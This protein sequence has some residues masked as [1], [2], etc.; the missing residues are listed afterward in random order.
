MFDAQY[1]HM[2]MQQ[3]QHNGFNKGQIQHQQQPEHQSRYPPLSEKSATEIMFDVMLSG[4]Q[5]TATS[6]AAFGQPGPTG[7]VALNN[8]TPPV[9]PSSMLAAASAR[10]EQQRHQQQHVPIVDIKAAKRKPV[11]AQIKKAIA[12]ASVASDVQDGAQTAVANAKKDKKPRTKRE[13]KQYICKYCNKQLKCKGNLEVHERVH[14]GDLPFSCHLCERKFTHSSNLK[15]HLRVHSG[16]R[17][18][19]CGTC[20]RFFT[21][22]SSL[23]RHIKIHQRQALGEQQQ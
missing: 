20:E 23:K 2:I 7:I 9:T 1:Q 21:T 10:H 17:P 16:E 6:P 13:R 12:A 8:V 11:S 19:K 14:S 5:T 3:Q 22:T 18:F 15:V 4:A